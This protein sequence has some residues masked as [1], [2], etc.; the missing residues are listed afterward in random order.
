ML[1][2]TIFSWLPVWARCPGCGRMTA[3]E[4]SPCGW[5]SAG[6]TRESTRTAHDPWAVRD[7]QGALKTGI[8]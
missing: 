8:V 1:Q 5:C 2:T 7:F 6:K 4:N 3:L